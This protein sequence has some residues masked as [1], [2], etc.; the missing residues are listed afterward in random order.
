MIKSVVDRVEQ[1]Q[2]VSNSFQICLYNTTSVK[3]RGVRLVDNPRFWEDVSSF[4][5]GH[6]VASEYARRYAN[7]RQQTSVGVCRAK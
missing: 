1:H 2:E 6:V 5:Q 7:T 3:P 4:T